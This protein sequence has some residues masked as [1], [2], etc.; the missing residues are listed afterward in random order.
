MAGEEPVT[1]ICH[2]HVRPGKEEDFVRL[3]RRHWP[4]LSELGVVTEEPARAY[5]GADDEGRPDYYEIFAWRSEAA[6]ERAHSHPDVLAIWEPMDALCEPRDGRPNM[7][8]PHV[9]R[10]AL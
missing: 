8:F 10:L 6:F 7:E 5:R 4:T 2:Y 1:V 3:L 9:R